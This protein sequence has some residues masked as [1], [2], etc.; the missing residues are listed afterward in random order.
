MISLAYITLNEEKYIERS[1]NSAKAIA[2]E[3]VVVDALSTD[4]TVKI[5]KNLGAKVFEEKWIDDFSHARNI[6]ISK[7]TQPWIVTL[8]AD[9]HLEG[10][11][12]NLIIQALNCSAQNEIVAW[13][14]PRKNHY[15]IH[16]SDSPF[17]DPPFYPDLQ[18]RI[19]QRK[20]E[21][22]YSGVVH[23]GVQQSIDANKIGCIGRIAV[24]IHHHMFRGNKE[25]FENSKGVYYSKLE[26]GEL[27]AR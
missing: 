16:D 15:P 6:M 4:D 5:C 22:Y 8:D 27:H 24:C 19:F 14:L 20:K 13:A 26:K 9:E 7:C 25:Q 2:D 11:N 1:I 23:E 12:L 17:F 21:I 3:I 18:V 10:E